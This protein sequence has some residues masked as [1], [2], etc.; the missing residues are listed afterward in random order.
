[1][2]TI[3]NAYINALLADAAYVDL[4]REPLDSDTNKP[5]LEKRK[6]ASG[7]EGVGRRRGPGVGVQASGSQASGSGLDFVAS[8]SGLDFEPP[9]T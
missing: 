4:A 3:T 9:P 7:S 5:A 2:T 6:R 8:G 1:M